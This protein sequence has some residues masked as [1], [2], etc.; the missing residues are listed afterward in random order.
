MGIPTPAPAAR[1]TVGTRISRGAFLVRGA[2]ASAA[3]FGAGA[4]SPF[5]RSA[6]AAGAT[7]IDI[8]NF[9]LT[10]EYLETDFY[11]KA[12]GLGLSPEV[13]KLG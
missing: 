6:L 12:I 2:L 11:A 9:A 8:V 13:K 10:L 7:D 1:R 4:I 3:V 5:V